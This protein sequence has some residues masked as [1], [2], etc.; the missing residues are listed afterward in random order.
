MTEHFVLSDEV[1]KVLAALQAHDFAAY[2]VGGCVRDLCRGVPPH[3]WDLCT[4]ATPD[5]MRRVFAGETLIATGERHGTMTLVRDGTAYEIT[6]FRTDGGYSDGRHPDAVCWGVSLAQDLQRRDFTVNAMALSADG[7][8]VDLHGGL[9][10]LAAKTL[11]CVGIPQQ[12][13]AEDALRML[14]LLRFAAALGFSVEEKTAAA[15]FSQCGAL[16]KIA[17]ERVTAECI[18]MFVGAHIAEALKKYGKILQPLVPDIEKSAAALAVLP[19][20]LSVRLA[21]ICH[22]CGTEFLQALRL[23]KKTLVQTRFLY[24]NRMQVFA[25][26]PAG[27]RHALYTYGTE[28]LRLLLALQKVLMPHLHSADFAALVE[29]EIAQNACVSRC[30]LAVNGKDAAALGIAP[31]PQTGKALDA[32]LQAVLDGTAENTRG[33]LLPVLSRFILS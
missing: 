29:K 22:F 5:E 19:P 9:S 8:L 28:N 16:Q 23:D 14:R 7:A 3:D 30:Q 6:T 21:A 15:A 17:A 33:A 25:L 12:R 13:F 31:G 1:K 11:R 2:A 20:I 18:V 10:D 4:A 27:A 24:E 26:I 32:A